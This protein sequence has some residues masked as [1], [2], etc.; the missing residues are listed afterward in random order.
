MEGMA[1]LETR[2]VREIMRARGADTLQRV[3]D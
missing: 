3:Q 1:K 2:Q